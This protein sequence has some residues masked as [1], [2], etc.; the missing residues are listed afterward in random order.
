[1]DRFVSGGEATKE[2]TL[3]TRIQDTSYVIYDGFMYYIKVTRHL[4]YCYV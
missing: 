4:I 1:M 3:R 2:Y